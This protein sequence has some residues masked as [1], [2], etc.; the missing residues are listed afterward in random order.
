MVIF[1]YHYGFFKSSNNASKGYR[2]RLMLK[3]FGASI[4]IPLATIFKVVSMK[5]YFQIIVAEMLQK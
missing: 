5:K 1:S 4:N 2:G 3:L